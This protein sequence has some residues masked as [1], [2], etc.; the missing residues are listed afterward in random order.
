MVDSFS[1]FFGYIFDISLS[2]KFLAPGTKSKNLS[3][4]NETGRLS[5]N[6]GN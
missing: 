3:L 1:L 5:R 4:E 6:V 2:F